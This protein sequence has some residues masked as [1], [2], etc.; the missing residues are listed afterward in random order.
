LN[1]NF[2]EKYSN[3]SVFALNWNIF[4]IYS[5]YSTFLYFLMRITVKTFLFQYK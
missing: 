5:K 3:F 1:L 2:S 4:N